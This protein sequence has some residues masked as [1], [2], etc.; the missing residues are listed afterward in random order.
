MT[1]TRPWQIALRADA[2]FDRSPFPATKAPA[3]TE[4]GSVLD[5]RAFGEDRRFLAEQV[6]TRYGLAIFVRDTAQEEVDF[7][8]FAKVVA[9]LSTEEWMQEVRR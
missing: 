7:P 9:Q 6:A 8:G 4:P 2:R 5:S 3:G 1:T